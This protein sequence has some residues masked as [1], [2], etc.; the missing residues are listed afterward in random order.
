MLCATRR[1]WLCSAFAVTEFKVLVLVRVGLEGL[2]WRLHL[3]G[4]FVFK[5]TDRMVALACTTLWCAIIRVS[6][7]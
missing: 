3:I 4:T 5:Q 7:R 1:L 2:I 6:T